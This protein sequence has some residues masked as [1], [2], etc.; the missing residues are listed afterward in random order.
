MSDFDSQMPWVIFYLLDQPYAV[1]ASHVRE[2]VEMPKTVSVPKSP[3]HIRGVINLRGKVIP[4]ID[5]RMKMGIQSQVKET[6]ELVSLLEQ[7]E[8]DHRNWITE[9]ESSVKEKRAFKLATDPHQ[10]AFGK[11]YDHF[12]TDNKL[13]AN[14]LRKFDTPHKKIHGIA[15]DVKNHEQNGEFEEAFNLINKTR[16][17]ELAMMIELFAE[18]RTLLKEGNREIAVILEYENTINAI[19]VDSVETIEKLSRAHIDDMPET[20]STEMNK[21][22]SGIGKRDKDNEMVQLLKAEYLVLDMDV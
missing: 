5:L 13:L 20:L 8:I 6:D 22:I 7:R 12:E 1:L 3:P 18:A 19:A 10:C 17:N 2:M 9:L 11:W 4:V 14:C 15:M 16:D 21:Y